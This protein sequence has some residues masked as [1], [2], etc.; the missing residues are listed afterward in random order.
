MIRF[1][2]R[3]MPGGDDPAGNG[4]RRKDLCAPW[5]IGG[6]TRSTTELPACLPLAISRG[7]LIRW[8]SL[9]I[10]LGSIGPVLGLPLFRDRPHA[11]QR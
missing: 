10:N 3:R 4:P 2:V 6:L 1:A 11:A 7:L 8:C 9:G 5:R